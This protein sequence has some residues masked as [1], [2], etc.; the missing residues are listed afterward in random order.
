MCDAFLSKLLRL[1]D[2][3]R[4]RYTVGNQNERLACLNTQAFFQ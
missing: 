2:F 1:A 3:P 4:L